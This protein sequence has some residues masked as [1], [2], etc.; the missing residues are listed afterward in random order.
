MI[1]TAPPRRLS[2]AALAL[3]LAAA[4]RPASPAPALAGP[5]LVGPGVIATAA[6]EYNPS[7]SPDG[8]TLVFARSEPEFRNAKIHVST[9]TNGGWSA[10]EQVPFSHPRH[11]DSDPTLSDDGRELYFVSNRPYPGRDST[12]QDLDLWRVPRV[13]IGWG[14]PE[15]VPG[16]NGRAQELGPQRRGEWLYFASTRSGMRGRL[17]LYRARIVGDS[18]GPVEPLA[19][20]TANNESDPEVSPDGSLLLFW[21]D[22]GNAAGGADLFV[23]ERQGDGWGQPRPLAGGASSPAFD[24][25]P[26][27]TADGRW[28]YFASTRADAAG[29]APAPADP[30]AP[31]HIYRMPLR[32]A[33]RPTAP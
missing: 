4:C 24:F 26:S 8:R 16:V 3:S 17:D 23:A 22:R 18:T 15:P 19:V 12:R 20:N 5:V 27:I 25:T 21:S 6:N 33:L 7:L 10:P 9:W 11:S 31:A 28:L 14:T 2:A 29:T 1:T 13:G 30:S 32:A